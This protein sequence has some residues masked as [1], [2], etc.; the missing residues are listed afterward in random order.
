MSNLALKNIKKS[1]GKVEVISGLNLEIG[2]GEFTVF[3]GPSGCGKTTLLR[4]I[5]GLEDISSGILEIDGVNSNGLEPIERGVAMVFQNYALYPH[6]SVEKN[7]GFSL[8][9]AG[10]KKDVIKA[11]VLKVAKILQIEDLLKRRPAELSGGQR[12]RVAI[13]RAIVRHPGVFLFDEPLSN[14]DAELRVSMR[15]ELAKLHKRLNTTMVY[16]THDQVEAMTLAD[17]IVVL[18][19][20][21]I[22]QVGSPDTLYDRPINKFVAGFIGQPAMNF[23]AGTMEANKVTLNSGQVIQGLDF[24]HHGKVQIGI[25]PEHYVDEINADIVFEVK[26]DVTE[27][28]G[29]TRFLY[30][31]LGSAESIVVEIKNKKISDLGDVV[32]VG[33]MEDS[34][35]IFDADGIRIDNRV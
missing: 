3:V 10:K 12:Q 9:T 30:G 34:L 19:D 18:R 23:F 5:A 32:K 8:A 22:E 31:T 7:I 2:D 11:E 27:N 33:V 4:M 26:V 21:K 15:I 20:G 1:F 29:T 28:L 13:G 6:M 24:E 25:R 16:V 14:L 35:Y 17:K